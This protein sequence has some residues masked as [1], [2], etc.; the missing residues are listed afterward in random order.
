MFSSLL[1][2]SSLSVWG[3]DEPSGI[4]LPMLQIDCTINPVDRADVI[5]G[6]NALFPS[7]LNVRLRAASL[8]HRVCPMLAWCKAPIN[9]ICLYANMLT[10]L[11]Y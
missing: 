8:L 1:T 6:K 4:L 11:T 7:L 3:R 5:Q 9:L 2:S 10:D